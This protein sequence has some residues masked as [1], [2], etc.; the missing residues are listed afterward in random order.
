MNNIKLNFLP[1]EER[2]FTFPVYRML[3]P[4]G[5]I[6]DI[7][8]HTYSLPE[9]SG[10]SDRTGYLVSFLPKDGF[11]LF[12]AYFLDS[13]NMT[14]KFLIYSLVKCLKKSSTFPF[15]Y[16]KAKY[17]GDRIEFTIQAFP[18]GRQII[19]LSP[20]FFENK[21]TFGFLID[22][23]FVK[24]PHVPFDKEVQKLSLSLNSEGNSNKNY[25]SDKH[26]LINKFIEKAY[27]DFR[28]L[29]ID[30]ISF[31]TVK[32]ELCNVNS[33]QLSKKEYIFN[34]RN[35][36]YS[37]F[38][39]VRNFGPYQ[40]VSAD[41]NF[42]FIFHDKYRQFAN[43]LYLS[44]L[45][46]LNPGTFP[47]F[48][49][50]FKIQFGLEN[51]KR[52]T[53]YNFDKESLDEA[54]NKAKEFRINEPNKR[55]IALYIEDYDQNNDDDASEHYFYLKYNFIKEDFP[56]QVVNYRKLGLRNA[57][58]WSTSNLALQI[59]A[60]L[61]GIPWIVKPSN[62]NCLI[63]GIGS[64]HKKDAKS[65][66]I[67]KYFAYTICLDSSGL[68]RSLDI[69]ADADTEESYLEQLQANL[70]A[71]LVSGKFD[72]YKTCVLHLPF[73]I[74]HSEVTALTEAIQ[75]IKLMNFVAIKINLESKFFGYSDHNTLVPYESSCVRLS[76]REFLVWFEG[77]LYGKE[78][79]DKRLSNPVHIEFL[80]LEEPDN[81][82]MNTYLQDVLN[83]SGANWRGFNSKSIPISIYYSK[84]ITEYTK[85]F[86]I[87]EG[88]SEGAISNKKPWFL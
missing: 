69:L 58:K 9:D 88:Y 26:R 22:F 13:R 63:L 81:I 51:V 80:N 6:E 73:K 38:Q 29:P 62:N 30:E 40:K 49:I 47:G 75:Q 37:Q 67:S 76:K 52:I 50:M 82:N 74:K 41:V 10:S 39:G 71:L 31:V 36:S 12:N 68:Y 33:F 77:L 28:T 44:L 57:L 23:R 87:I 43:E 17:S 70:V 59:F 18:Q 54:I 3:R 7:E 27:I 72:A 5:K 64:S 35:T 8:L 25:Y 46:K 56:L 42:I 1:I 86:E 16:I 83:L 15:E 24:H 65:G 85:A 48:N 45:G 60:K 2:D 66:K 4:E 34:N 55:Y 20:Y 53:L 61:G 32:D 78:I 21:G 84:I 79:V 14:K 19:Y 11:E